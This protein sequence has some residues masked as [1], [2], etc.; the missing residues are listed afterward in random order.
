MKVIKQTNG[1]NDPLVPK[2]Q[3]PAF[4][5]YSRESRGTKKVNIPFQFQGERVHNF[6]LTS[7][8]AP[9]MELE[10]NIVK[11]C[12]NLK[13]KIVGS[14]IKLVKDEDSLQ[15]ENDLHGFSSDEIETS[16]IS[17][18]NKKANMMKVMDRMRTFSAGSVE[19]VDMDRR[20]ETHSAKPEG[21]V[22]L[23][24]RGIF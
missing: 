21:K 5:T 18:E 24:F 13:N 9:N 3:A 22:A 16:V 8:T 1:E 7:I 20:D 12:L 6:T 14:T 15:Q 23:G 4:K 2:H 11:G 17:K 19:A 10:E